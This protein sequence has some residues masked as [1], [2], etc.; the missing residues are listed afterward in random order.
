MVEPQY[1]DLDRRLDVYEYDVLPD[2]QGYIVRHRRKVA[3]VARVRHLADLADLADLVEWAGRRYL[4]APHV[5][6]LDNQRTQPRC[7]LLH[8]QS[9][10]IQSRRKSLLTM[11]NPVDVHEFLQVNDLVSAPIIVTG[12]FMGVN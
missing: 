2:S 1:F 4:L 9:E 3:D 8:C 10:S 11:P 5:V 7:K 12:K 6:V